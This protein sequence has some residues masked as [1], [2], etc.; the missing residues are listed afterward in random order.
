MTPDQ[1]KVK[2]RI[3]K[4][5]SLGMD[6]DELTIQ[7]ERE[8]AATNPGQQIGSDLPLEPELAAKWGGTAHVGQ[9]NRLLSAIQN[10][11]LYK[12]V[13]RAYKNTRRVI[14]R[15]LHGICEKLRWC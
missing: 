1:E 13:K 12:F 9:S 6:L 4:A 5:E 14:H 8:P 2:K 11:K 10:S 3:A 7:E 15:F